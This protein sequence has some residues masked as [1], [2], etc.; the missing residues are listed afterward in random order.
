M[1]FVLVIAV[2]LA[3]AYGA[4]A[5]AVFAHFMVRTYFEFLL[6]S[7]GFFSDGLYFALCK[8][9]GVCSLT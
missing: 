3:W 8:S 4:C 6:R 2:A 7:I 1:R 9:L 5:K